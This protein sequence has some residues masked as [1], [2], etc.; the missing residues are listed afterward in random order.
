MDKFKRFKILTSI[1][2][3]NGQKPSAMLEHCPRG[4]VKRSY[5]PVFSCGIRLKR[6]KAHTRLSRI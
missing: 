6:F 5:L 4:E 2:P 3:L 1:L